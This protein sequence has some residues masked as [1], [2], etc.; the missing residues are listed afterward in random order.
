MNREKIYL[1]DLSHRGREYASEYIPLGIGCIKAFLTENSKHANSFEAKLFKDPQKFINSYLKERPGLVGFS[2]Y[3]W[4]LDLSTS[5]AREIKN[6]DPETFI[7]FGGPNFPLEEALKAKWLK[8]FDF[9]DL[10]IVGDGE[11]PF[12][13]V[14]DIWFETQNMEAV[15]EAEIPGCHYL[16]DGKVYHPKKETPRISDLNKVPSPYLLGYFDEFLEEECFVP[17]LETT[18]GCP[19][20]CTFCEKG[21]S[22][23]GNVVRKSVEFFEEELYYVGRKYQGKILALADDNFGMYRQDAQFAE[24]IARVKERCDYP[25]HINAAAGKNHQENILRTARILQGSWQVGASVQSLDPEVLSNI[26]RK[27]ISLDVLISTAKEADSFNA[28]TRS[29]VIL[30]LPGDTKEKHLETLYSLVDAGIKEILVFTLILLEG[31]ELGSLKQRKLWG[32]KTKYRLNFGCVGVYPFEKKEIIAGEIEEVCVANKS[33]SFED[34][35][36]C[37]SFFLTLGIFY[38][39]SISLELLNFLENFQIKPSQFLRAI[40]QNKTNFSENLLEFYQNYERA[41]RNELWDNKEDLVNYVKGNEENLEKILSGELGMNII[42]TYR[43]LALVNLI[44]E[45][46]EEAFKVAKQLLKSKGQNLLDQSSSYLDELKKF[47]ILRKKNIFEYGKSF[48]E[49]FL[50][51]FEALFNSNFHALPT[52]VKDAMRI[53]FFTDEEQIKM[54]SVHGTESLGIRKILSRWDVSRLQRKLNF[55]D[56]RI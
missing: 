48:V 46:M 12:A 49:D 9:V 35:I 16:N 1:C 54:M 37:R 22:V 18:R 40:H 44:E 26:K 29:E 4:N 45:I 41:T 43:G 14:F 19:F 27:N 30:A 55:H 34:Y 28:N 25:Y 38:A 11:E 17:M 3:S 53:E 24:A 52:E 15:K 36:E 20:T 7:I 42:Y 56:S 32:L 51:D 8:K 10:Y 5:L 47:C 2:N 13:E 31:T 23:W 50:F 33:M 21:V 6:R 39:D